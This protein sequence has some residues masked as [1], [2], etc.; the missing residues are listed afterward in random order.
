MTPPK[1]YRTKLT[2]AQL[3]LA[4]KCHTE[5]ARMNRVL[6]AQ[7]SPPRP[8]L[9]SE[10]LESERFNRDAREEEGKVNILRWVLFGE[11]Y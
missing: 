6:A 10:L 2:R 5:R 8:C 11:A 1:G 9:L 4:L 7:A 3:V